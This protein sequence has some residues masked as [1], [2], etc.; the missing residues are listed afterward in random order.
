MRYNIDRKA[1]EAIGSF[2]RKQFDIV[3]DRGYT[4]PPSI[5]KPLYLYHLKHIK[6]N[7]SYQLKQCKN[8]SKNYLYHKRCRKP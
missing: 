7:L 5:T 1:T 4:E 3:F 6:Q 8:V 2:S